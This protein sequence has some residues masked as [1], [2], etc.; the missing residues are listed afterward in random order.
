MSTAASTARVQPDSGGQR[1]A[2]PRRNPG[3]HAVATPASRRRPKLVY[4]VVAMAGAIAILVAQ[5]VLSIMTTGSSYELSKLSQQQ[6][7]L[8]WQKQI[9]YDDVAGLSS[10]QN[11]AANAT[12][13]GM[14]IDQSPSYLR[15]SDAKILGKSEPAASRSTVDALGRGQVA[16]ALIAKDKLVTDPAKTISGAEATSASAVDATTPPPLTE[17]LPVPQTH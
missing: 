9:L 7:Q 17:G 4:G 8:T 10:P 13:L 3:L 11:L 14:V 16:N 6:R 12:A 15:L 1:S 5:M 2:A